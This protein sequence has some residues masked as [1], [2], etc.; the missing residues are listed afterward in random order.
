MKP[1]SYCCELAVAVDARP[2]NGARGLKP[3]AIAARVS[4]RAD[5]RPG[6]G[7]RG[8]KLLGCAQ[9]ELD[10]WMRAPATGRED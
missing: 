7:A 4:A 3:C 1:A 10:L 8:L 5:A 6:N 2:G 9:S